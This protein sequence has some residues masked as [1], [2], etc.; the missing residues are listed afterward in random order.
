MHTG[1]TR[2]SVVI[3]GNT[4]ISSGAQAR[5]FTTTTSTATTATT[6]TTDNIIWYNDIVDHIDRLKERIIEVEVD[7]LRAGKNYDLP[8]GAKLSIDFNGNYEIADRN[9]KVVYKAN[10]LREFNRFINASD[11]LE[12]FIRYA[13]EHGARQGDVLGIPIEYFIGWLVMKAAE[14]DGDPMPK[15]IPT[16][17]SPALPRC[18]ACGR[19][20]KKSFVEKGL[21]FCDPAHYQRF[22]EKTFVQQNPLTG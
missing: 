9:A 5:W 17:P 21:Q 20:L 8:D 6:A 16:L 4:M 10:N 12:D 22:L 11:L 19:F 15:D 3:R 7:F 18:R 13:G 1:N 2:N 14:T